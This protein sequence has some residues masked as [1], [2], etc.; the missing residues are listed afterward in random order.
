MR[1]VRTRRTERCA[2][3]ACCLLAVAACEVDR[4]PDEPNEV[5]DAGVDAT[6]YP[7]TPAFCARPGADAIRDIFCV[8]PQPAIQSL[9]ELAVL[10]KLKPA[11]VPD[12]SAESAFYALSSVAVL[13]HSTA[14]SG[15]LVSPINPRV[16]VMGVDSFMAFQRGARARE[17]DRI[18]ESGSAVAGS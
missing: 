18:P 16:V 12:T 2:W 7:E 10:L 1:R 4:A 8:E 14:L 5:A 9:H 13:G 11:A 3:L 6:V 15:H 17:V